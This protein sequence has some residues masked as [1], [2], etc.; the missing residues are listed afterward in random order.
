MNNIFEASDLNNEG[1]NNGITIG[2]VTLSKNKSQH[3]TL[4]QH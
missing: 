2:G 1:S 4:F 3:Q